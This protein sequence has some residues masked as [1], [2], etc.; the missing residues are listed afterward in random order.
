MSSDYRFLVIGS[1]GREHAICHALS[2]SRTVKQV[3][4]APGNPGTA[5]VAENV[6]LPLDD[7]SAVA[8]FV[9]ANDISA[10]IVGPEAPLVAGLTDA[11]EAAGVLVVGPSQAAAQ[12]EGSKAFAKAF[13]QRQG[14]PT[15]AHGTFTKDQVDAALEYVD[16][17]NLP[18][19][20]KASGLAAGKGVL[21]CES[22][23]LAQQAVR[24]ILIKERF[25]DAGAEVVVEEFLPG[26]EASVFALCDGE[27]YVLLPPAKDYK[28]IGV[29]DKGL[30]TGGMGAV[31]PVP[32]MDELLLNEVEQSVIGPTLKGMAFEGTPFKGFLFVG[33][34]IVDRKPYVLEYNVRLGD[35][36]AQCILPRIQNDFGELM[37]ATVEQRLD[38]KKMGT[39][40]GAA[41]TIVLAS[42]GYPVEY[43][44][45]FEISGFEDVDDDSLV[46]HAG[47]KQSG[48][49][50]V[51]NGGRVLAVTSISN[52]IDAARL[53]ALANCE[54][55]KFE[56]MYYRNDIGK[57]LL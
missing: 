40:P 27:N 10:V 6:S 41:V 25:G 45:G 11:L 21:I 53:K 3:Y 46:F 15:A 32:F 31:S 24:D 36:E 47:T 19:V 57:D 49:H 14:I 48:S 8:E 56:G 37:M 17:L 50:Y 54:E 30:N 9:K 22:Y 26:I 4:A 38:K 5:Q 12:L 13:M 33:L 39:R 44:K 16:G 43:E 20:V 2:A 28:R 51:T 35:P 1:G 42:E 52:S 29:G 34:M 18:I 55:L 7:F 23:T